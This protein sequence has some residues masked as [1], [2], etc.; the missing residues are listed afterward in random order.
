MTPR[1][2]DVVYLCYSERSV[3]AS[4]GFQ[5]YDAN[6]RAGRV[7]MKA[8]PGDG[9]TLTVEGVM[10]ELAFAKLF[11]LYPPVAVLLRGDLPKFDT[12]LHDGRRVDVKTTRRPGGKM[13]VARHKG[14]TAGVDL[15]ALMTGEPPGPWTYRGA[16]TRADLI[17]PGRIQ[18]PIPGKPAYVALQRELREIG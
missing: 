10:G 7:E 12:L 8:S 14:D 3:A 1:I 2:G 5:I 17:V 6:V 15:Y 4:V 9:L 11:N 16:M 18:V 13:Y